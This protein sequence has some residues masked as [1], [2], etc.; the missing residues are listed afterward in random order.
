MLTHPDETTLYREGTF[1]PEPGIADFEVLMRRP[2]LFAVA[3]SRISGGRAAVVQRLSKGLNVN[4]A[5]V[6]IVR[7]LF[8]MVKSL[9]DYAWNTRRLPETT[10]ALRDSF[11]NAKSPEQFLFVKLPESL[12]LPAFSEEVQKKEGINGFFDSLNTNLRNLSEA[13]NFAISTARDILLKAC[14]FNGGDT[15]WSELRNTAVALEPS[16]TEPHLLTFLKRVTQNGADSSGMESVLALVAN[17]PP[18][19]WTDMDVDRFPEAAAAMGRAFRE[20]VRSTAV[21]SVSKVQLDSLTPKERRQAEDILASVRNHLHR[22]DND[23]SPRALRA[24]VS[25]LLEELSNERCP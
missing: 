10:L 19:K 4:P 21:A 23:I 22:C 13:S 25:Q 15:H 8:R 3:G 17:R 1:L 9:P 12:N 6:P 18:Q 20:A 5:T 7:A 16:V 14:G 2:E 24:A 11:Q